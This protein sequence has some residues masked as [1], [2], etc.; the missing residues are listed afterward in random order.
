MSITRIILKP[1]DS[2]PAL[3]PVPNRKVIAGVVVEAVAVAEAAVVDN[4]AVAAD[5]A[6]PALPASAPT[7]LRHP[8]A[9]AIRRFISRAGICAGGTSKTRPLHS[10]VVA[11]SCSCPG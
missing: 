11:E 8:V 4:V 10:S 7:A 2:P 9:A 5:R 3:P 1:P 6:V